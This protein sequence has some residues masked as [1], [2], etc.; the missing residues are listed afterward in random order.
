MLSSLRW[1]VFWGVEVHESDINIIHHLPSRT[2]LKHVIVRLNN[3]HLNRILYAKKQS[4][5]VNE[6][7]F[8][9]VFIQEDLTTQ[10]S[11][12]VRFIKENANVD[13]V[14]TSEGKIHVNLKEE[15]FGGKGHY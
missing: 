4:L 2:S 8:K 12:M 3:S 10:R 9:G 14:R 1:P 5:N 13:R 11:K 7:P 6:C 15:G